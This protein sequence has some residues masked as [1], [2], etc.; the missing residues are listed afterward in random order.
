MKKI[1]FSAALFVAAIGFANAQ[2]EGTAKKC[3]KAKEHCL[4]E[5][6]DVKA[7]IK[8]QF[9]QQVGWLVGERHYTPAEA[10]KEAFE[11]ALFRIKSWETSY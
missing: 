8:N 9:E 2:S 11:H 1:I 4:K 5:L 3:D 10:E 7:H 6:Q